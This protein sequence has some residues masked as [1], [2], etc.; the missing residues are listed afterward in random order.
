MNKID[1]TDGINCE[2]G[3]AVNSLFSSGYVVCLSSIITQLAE[4]RITEIHF[5]RRRVLTTAIELLV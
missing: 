2:I 5:G 1:D 3:K 4:E